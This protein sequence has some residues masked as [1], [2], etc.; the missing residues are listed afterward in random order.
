MTKQLETTAKK[1]K[2]RE[3][4]SPEVRTEEVFETLALTCTKVDAQQCALAEGLTTAR[5]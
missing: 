3:Y 5:S 4:E 1:E 2:G